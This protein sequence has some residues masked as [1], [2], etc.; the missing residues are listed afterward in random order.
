MLVSV[1]VPVYNC[2]NSIE[3]CVNSL[4]NQVFDSY[5]II[6][7]DNNS[8]DNSY[9]ICKDYA[10]SDKRIKAISCQMQGANAARKLGFDQSLGEYICFVDSDD[11]VEEDYIKLLYDSVNNEGSDLSIAAY[12]TEFIHSTTTTIPPFEDGYV[13]LDEYFSSLFG[14]LRNG[15]NL[16]GF[17][18]NRMY[19]RSLIT[20][21][22]FD[23]VTNYYEDHLFNI[24][25]AKTISKVSV[26]L[27]PI[28]HYV[29]NSNSLTQ[30]YYN[31]RFE[32]ILYVDKSLSLLLSEYQVLNGYERYRRFRAE[33]FFAVIEN[34]CKNDNYYKYKE[35]INGLLLSEFGKEG[36]KILWRY[37][38]Y[39]TEK[40]ITILFKAKLWKLL[41]KFRRFRIML[42]RT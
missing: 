37:S 40:V 8:S 4:M 39:N 18:W 35:E 15:P 33:S 11:Y 13:P 36:A 20:D 2:E 22:C 6:L 9:K 26:V 17:L 41:Y 19:K 34:A 10:T 31:N 23:C 16:N 42:S 5:E 38:Y 32:E 7:V 25:Y 14:D 27:K 3:K 12:Y 30:Q 1:I 29:V 24:Y 28:Y 21:S